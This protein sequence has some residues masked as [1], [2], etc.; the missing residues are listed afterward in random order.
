MVDPIR[1][2]GAL[3][4]LSAVDE[5]RAVEIQYLSKVLGVEVD[6]VHEALATLRDMNYVNVVRDTLVY[7]TKLGIMKINSTFC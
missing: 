1:L 6:K 7:L 5:E 3:H 2:L 4:A